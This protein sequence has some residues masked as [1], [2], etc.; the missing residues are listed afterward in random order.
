MRP[1]ITEMEGK[2]VDFYSGLKGFGREQMSEVEG[3]TEKIIQNVLWLVEN[4]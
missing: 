4:G 3:S 1:M 2:V